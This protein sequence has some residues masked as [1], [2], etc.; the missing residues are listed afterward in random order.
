MT[1]LRPEP[2]V[3]DPRISAQ[4]LATFLA[5]EYADAGQDPD[6]GRGTN[7]FV[8]R[9]SGDPSHG[10][11]PVLGSVAEPPFFGTSARSSHAG[12]PF[13]TLFWKKP[14]SPMPRWKRSIVIG[15]RATC[16]D[17]AVG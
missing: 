2:D 6:F 10:P 8:R 15:L 7:A 14:F 4:D 17:A 11:N 9:Y 1:D 3:S 5:N 12:K 16:G 13:V